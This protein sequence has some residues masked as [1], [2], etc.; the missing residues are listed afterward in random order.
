[1]KIQSEI[2][3]QPFRLET[4]IDIYVRLDFAQ[5]MSLL[6]KVQKLH[7]HSLE[8]FHFLILPRRSMADNEKENKVL[9][10]NLKQLRALNIKHMIKITAKSL[11]LQCLVSTKRSHILKQTCR[12][13]LQVCLSMCDLLVDTRHERV[14][15]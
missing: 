9:I 14:K 8:C 7:Y 12:F 10:L 11:T 6:S 4:S 15:E 1:M 3:R 5:S 13:Q 2:H